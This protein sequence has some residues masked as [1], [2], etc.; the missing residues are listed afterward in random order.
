M[1]QIIG[2]VLPSMAGFVFVT[3]ITVTIA[4]NKIDKI[5]KEQKIIQSKLDLL[6]K[7]EDLDQ[8]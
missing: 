8:S 1:N 6:L 3:Y 7:N 5:K 4:A 2:I